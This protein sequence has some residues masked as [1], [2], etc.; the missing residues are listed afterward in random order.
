M[1]EALIASFRDIREVY[2]PTPPPADDEESFQQ[3]LA[4]VSTQASSPPTSTI[5]PTPPPKPEYLRSQKVSPSPPTSPVSPTPSVEPEY[6]RSQ[7]I[8]PQEVQPSQGVLP[9][10]DVPPSHA[11]F[12]PT[13]FPYAVTEYV[14]AGKKIALNPIWYIADPKPQSIAQYLSLCLKGAQEWP[15]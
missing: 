11:G 13:T 15:P 1:N 14:K 4:S 12:Q 3:S 6:L 7:A 2:Q 9:S 5:K 8:S 10:Q